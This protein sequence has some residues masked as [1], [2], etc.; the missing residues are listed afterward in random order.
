MKNLFADIHSSLESRLCRRR[1]LKAGALALGGC[2]LPGA[3]W[4]AVRGA[5]PV[6][7]SLSLYNLHTGESL[8]TVYWSRGQY[9]PGA[10]ADINT[11]LRDHRTEETIPIDTGLLDFLHV[12]HRDMGSQGP[13]HIISGYRSPD[14]NTSLHAKNRGVAR[15]S[16]HMYGKAVDIRMPGQNLSALRNMAISLKRG[17]VGYYPRSDFVHVDVGRVRHW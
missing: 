7:R 8:E 13:L 1:F 14:T 3:V 9:D 5:L 6:E 2:L 10:L 4:G 17:G 16:L 11:I 12:L 15:N